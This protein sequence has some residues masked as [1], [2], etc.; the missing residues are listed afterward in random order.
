MVEDVEL[1]VDVLGLRVDQAGFATPQSA[2]AV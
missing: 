1:R 2:A